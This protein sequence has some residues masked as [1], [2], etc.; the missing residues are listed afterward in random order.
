[1]FITSVRCECSF[2]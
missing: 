2:D 1:M